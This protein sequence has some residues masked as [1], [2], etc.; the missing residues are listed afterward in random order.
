MSGLSRLF[1]LE[2]L[3]RSVATLVV[4]TLLATLGI[5]YAAANDLVPVPETVPGL[6]PVTAKPLPEQPH[7]GEIIVRFKEQPDPESMQSI[8]ASL[9]GGDG[10]LQV[11]RPLT[12]DGV[13]ATLAALR[14][15]PNVEFAELNYLFRA[16]STNDPQSGEQSALDEVAAEWGWAKGTTFLGSIDQANP[17]TVAVIDTGVDT[18]HADLD[19]RLLPGQNVITGAPDATEVTDDATDGH[20]THIAGLIAAGTENGVGIAGLAGPF[21]VS[22]LPIKVLNADGF[23]SMLDIATGIR[24]AAD[25]GATIINLSFGS[26][27]PDYP[28]T[29]AEAVKYAQD[30]GAL[31]IAAAGNEGGRVE[32]Y[33]PASLPGVLAV[34]ATGRDH[35]PAVFTNKSAV[36]APGV[37]VLSTLPNDQYG[38]LSGTSVSAAV[39]SGV[40]AVLRSVFPAKSSTQ[41][42]DALTNGHATYTSGNTQYKVLSM[43]RALDLL[44][45]GQTTP[46]SIT[47]IQPTDSRVH[48]TTQFVAQMR[49]ASKVDYVQ[50]RLEDRSRSSQLLGTL[51]GDLQ[52]GT[53]ELTWD[54]TLVPD[55]FYTIYAE[56]FNA[57]NAL[58]ATGSY[59]AT[60]YNAATSGLSLQ[61]IKPD[62]TPAAGAAVTVYYAKTESGP[63][64]TLFA[65]NAD[66]Q[67]NLVIPGAKATDGNQFLV[68]AQ[69]SDPN[70]LYARAVT[71]P[72]NVTLDAEG[73][74]PVTIVGQDASGSPAVG[75]TVW[76]GLIAG[77]NLPAVTGTAP[78]A[79]LDGDGM[80]TATVSEGLYT[81]RQFSQEFAE[82]QVVHNVA[83]ADSTTV[84]IAPPAGGLATL[85]AQ[86]AM[87]IYDTYGVTWRDADGFE[88][89]GPKG[90]S[91]SVTP[92]E[93]SAAIHAEAPDTYFRYSYDFTVPTLSVAPGETRS[94][95]FGGGLRMTLSADQSGQVAAGSAVSFAAVVTDAGGNELQIGQPNLYVTFNGYPSSTSWP[96]W[97]ISPNAAPGTY[98]VHAE[99]STGPLGREVVK[100]QPITFEVVSGAQSAPL[101]VKLIGKDGGPVFGQVYLLVKT[102]GGYAQVL[103]A[104]INNGVATFASGFN[105]AAQHAI[106]LSGVS[107]VAPGMMGPVWLF[108]PVPAGPGPVAM[109]IDLNKMSLHHLSLQGLNE[110]NRPLSGQYYGYVQGADGTFAG[111]P[112]G[113]DVWVPEGRYLFQAVTVGSNG[114]PTVNQ[115]NLFSPVVDLPTDL[116][117]DGRIVFGGS[118]QLTRL[119]VGLADSTLTF[120]AVGLFRTD[121]AGVGSPRLASKPPV[122]VTPGNYSVEALLQRQDQMNSWSYWLAHPV[123]ASGGES[124]SWQIDTNF[125]AHLSLDRSVV[126]PNSLLTTT[127]LIQD[128]FG[129]RL[130]RLA[131][132][133]EFGNVHLVPTGDPTLL[134][135][136]LV[137]KNSA[138][139]EVYRERQVDALTTDGR[140]YGAWGGC[141]T[142]TCPPVAPTTGP[143]S[144]FGQTLTVPGAWT[145][146]SYTAHI[147]LGV[148]PQGPVQAAPVRFTVSSAPVL[149]RLPASTRES[150][151]TVSGTTQ[152]GASVA[153]SYRLDGGAPQ[154][155]GVVTAGSD[156]R[157]SLAVALTAEG[158]Y[159]FT[160]IASLEGKSSAPSLP[161]SIVSDRTAPG[162]PRSLAWTSPDLTHIRLTWEGSAEADLTAYELWRDGA[163]IG[164]VPASGPLAFLDEGLGPNTAYSYQVFAID[165]ASNHSEAAQTNAATGEVADMERPTA[166]A[167]L[168]ATLTEPS[169]AQLTWEAATDNVAVVG[170]HVYRAVDGGAPILQATVTD[171]LTFVEHDL[172]TAATYAYTVTAIDAA[173]NE[174]VPSDAALVTTASMLIKDVQVR[175]RPL[176]RFGAALPGATVQI[177]LNGEPK[178]QAEAVIAYQTWL[179]ESGALLTAP[180]ELELTVALTATAA[181]PGAYTGSTTLPVGAALVTKVTGRL[182]DGSGKVVTAEAT[183]GLPQ[184]I[185]GSLAVQLGVPEG[186]TEADVSAALKDGAKLTLWSDTVG[187]GGQLTPIAPGQY[188]VPDLTPADDYQLRLVT[189]A[190]WELARLS[191]IKVYG[192][193]QK[194]VAVSPRLPATVQLE[195]L[196]VDGK[197]TAARGTFRGPD[198]T[199]LNWSAGADGKSQVSIGRWAGDSITYRVWI[200]LPYVDGHSVTIK[201]NPGYNQATLQLAKYPQGV[202]QGTVRRATDHTPIADAT[203]SVYQ[204]PNGFGWTAT[205]KTDANGFYSLTAYAGEATLEAAN[206]SGVARTLD[207]VTVT[208]PV[209]GTA[210]Q[211]LQLR[212]RGYGTVTVDLYTRTPGGEWQG[213]VLL[214]WRQAFHYH[215]SATTRSGI[216]QGYPIRPPAMDGETVK[217]CVNGQESKLPDQCQETVFD[218]ELNAHVEL[219][220]DGA[221]VSPIVLKAIDDLTGEPVTIKSGTLFPM[222]TS[223]SNWRRPAVQLLTNGSVETRVVEN[224]TY[225][226][227]LIGADGKVGTAR[228]QSVLGESKEVEVRMKSGRHFQGQPGN[229]LF[230]SQTEFG[231]ESSLTFRATFTNQGPTVKNAIF[232]LNAPGSETSDFMTVFAT[233]D[234]LQTSAKASDSGNFEFWVGE[235]AA[236]QSRT[237]TYTVRVNSTNAA[238]ILA[239]VSQA[240]LMFTEGSSVY[241]ETIGVATVPYNPVSIDVPAEVNQQQILV[242][243]NASPVGG[244]LTVYA[245]DIALGT[246]TVEG[247]GKWSLPI[248][249]PGSATRARTHKLRV[250]VKAPV[251]G[252][253]Y[254]ATTTVKY[255]P[256]AVVMKSISLLRPADDG[257]MVGI[258]INPSSVVPTFPFVLAPGKPVTVAVQF[259]DPNRV[260]DPT[261]EIPGMGTVALQKGP[262]GLYRGEFATWSGSP[263]ALYTSYK[264]QPLPFDQVSQPTLSDMRESLPPALYNATVVS[265]STG[266][267]T[268]ADPTLGGGYGSM[269]LNLDGK[270]SLQVSLSL[271]IEPVKITPDEAKQAR[272]AA[273]G[274]PVWDVTLSHGSYGTS[275]R[276]YMAIGG[277]G[278]I[279]SLG[280]I[281]LN[282]IFVGTKSFELTMKFLGP[283]SDIAQLAVA[284][285]SLEGIHAQ[286][287]AL[288]DMAE[289]CGG[290]SYGKYEQQLKAMYEDY[291]EMQVILTLGSVMNTFLIASGVGT[292][293]GAITSIALF[294]L[295]YAT[296]QQLADQLDRIRRDMENDRNCESSKRDDDP[297]RKAAKPKWIMDPGGYVYEAVPENRLPGVTTSLLEKQPDGGMLFWDSTWY[298]QANPLT[299]DAEGLYAWDVPEGDWQVVY[300]KDGYLT[301]TSPVLHVPPPQTEVNQGLISLASPTVESIKAGQDGAYLDVRFSQYMKAA[302]LTEATILVTL[303]DGT[304]ALGTVTPL[305]PAVT[306][307]GLSV[308]RVVRF[309]PV[310]PLVVGASYL[311]DV[312]ALVQNYAEST[313]TQDFVQAVVVPADVTPPGPVTGLTVTPADGAL[314]LHWSNPVDADFSHVRLAWS[315]TEY[316]RWVET[317]GERYD[318]TGL[319]NGV[320]YSIKIVTVDAAGNESEPILITGKPVDT[321]A[322]GEVTA[323][324]VIPG[325]HQVSVLWTD[326]IDADLAKVRI[327]WTGS[328]GATGSAVT[329]RGARVFTLTDLTDLVTYTITLTAIDQVGNASAPVGLTARLVPPDVV[330][331][332][333]AANQGPATFASPD[334]TISLQVMPKT[335]AGPVSVKVVRL[336][337]P[338]WP[339]EQG[340]KPLTDAFV[341]TSSEIP[342]HPITITLRYDKALL[343]A[344]EFKQVALYRQDES[345][346]TRWVLVGGSVNPGQGYVRAEV[347]RPG[348]Y[349]LMLVR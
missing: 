223:N 1:G 187:S 158:T 51:Q 64:Q 96:T 335:F 323:A 20:G 12:A 282:P 269:V 179:D 346:P 199:D 279:N 124:Q 84:S 278:G 16:A 205:A 25:Q 68:V 120:P 92:G 236:G 292:I 67:G 163:L 242:A 203:I 195:V 134:A 192:G 290:W 246:T 283:A 130:V 155:A 211:D 176:T 247:A 196:D 181:A 208:V 295:S 11:V 103:P 43:T 101:S 224:G 19:G 341:L 345:D 4:T 253:V 216:F 342:A 310:Q 264:S 82:Y 272:M 69:G 106:I 222:A 225:E 47:F 325:A 169:V 3:R 2:R 30:R 135:P 289:K 74:Y 81:W 173:G 111:G 122:Y 248:T 305:A 232:R 274:A 170:Y 156:G 37:D 5:P 23:G 251:T 107:F 94:I 79:T 126:E 197:P 227:L 63:L 136:F 332:D 191:G 161:V 276:G 86:P 180:R 178:R 317:S 87:G 340:L 233:I 38:A 230:V 343:G 275:V 105:P 261:A 36:R 299:T 9:E 45:G 315:L 239:V 250:E 334:D 217:V 148:G 128:S 21:P 83:V 71:A 52:S 287:M 185:I 50:F 210:Q 291:I 270:E 207:P 89:S 93:Y 142:S 327:D 59:Y 237:V 190:G 266:G 77:P 324:Q 110:Q 27:L 259:S 100:S 311:V 171:G 10:R 326:P 131:L 255:D 49:D 298:G 48:G 70:F 174:S 303:P 28:V 138:G 254:A 62:G 240:S 219:R 265:Q 285:G 144:Y 18:A 97:Q 218:S 198:G 35:R 91:I 238:W 29:L 329:P 277:S 215:L 17:V 164:T 114:A 193:Y 56:A 55:G 123:T 104:S 244:L 162:A 53:F 98:S 188:L 78:L 140:Y 22:I 34:G 160:A 322:P 321:T 243:G 300:Q 39:A 330:V 263:G 271:S 260:I 189:K 65:G 72:A 293:G 201:L 118:D 6:S 214:D 304:P 307:N 60:V 127:N 200:G 152:A 146:D 14:A 331:L 308:T 26:R 235:I 42:A 172:A 166:P 347:A 206:V 151:V 344:G 112:I 141:F 220:L 76:A 313:M 339:T 286:F 133:A 177:A 175:I 337:W 15:D 150:H 117:A 109:T 212:S 309:T 153:V 336:G 116:P 13:E 256:N 221:K 302:S 252:E 31:V 241:T 58:L 145:G 245:G 119:A 234:G 306:E 338:T 167:N 273:G 296:D 202:I 316:G 41:V 80:A 113:N 328:D 139:Q 186:A 183:A 262:D 95:S 121:L 90:S 44:N 99:W 204:K 149:D 61:V 257:S 147:E 268:T 301:T 157:F 24:S 297:R 143:S 46:N 318:L 249:L 209:G 294:A 129:N 349:A 32:G 85:E 281:N 229:D 137:I 168:Q 182:S 213:P 312:S 184:A 40:A 231:L 348:V 66:L 54:S 314:T 8:G 108:E 88:L 159:A 280:P 125:S 194:S 258:T 7:T 154:E 115:Y 102:P 57:D 288:Y 267:N 73:A 284:P 333:V 226:V 165:W 132:D 320:T 75:A 228:F 33:Y 319:A